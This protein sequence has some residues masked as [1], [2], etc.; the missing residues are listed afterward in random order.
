MSNTPLPYL[1]REPKNKADKPPLLILLHGMGSNEQDL[2][3][4]A[5][6]L[7]DKFLVISARG[8]R[9]LGPNR[10]AWYQVDFSTGRPVINKE[11][12]IESRQ[13]ILDFIHQLKTAHDFD[14]QQVYLGG[15]SQGAIMSYSVGLTHPEKVKGI[16]ALSG[17]LLE[18]VRPNIPKTEALK[19]LEI[20][21]SHGTTDA[22]LG[23]HY[24]HESVSYL[25]NLGLHPDYQEY[26]H[27]HGI[28]EE[29]ILDLVSWLNHH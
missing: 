21:I 5:D 24:A 3:S 10:F 23:A 13:A 22:T 11:Q 1:V 8:P 2:F 29:M 19:N 7:P 9:V 16:V 27:G 4:F 17:R 15:F 20:F 26:Q 14:E 12:E 6:R 25:E 28:N 18:E